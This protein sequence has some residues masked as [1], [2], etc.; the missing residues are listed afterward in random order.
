[1]AFVTGRENPAKGEPQLD[2]AALARF[3]GSLVF[4]MGVTTAEAWISQLIAHGLSPST[5]AAIVR[6]SSHPDQLTIRCRLD[7]VVNRL[8]R[9]RIM[10]PPVI[11]IVGAAVEEGRIPPWFEQR[12]LFGQS[13]LITRCRRADRRPRQAAAGTRRRGPYQPAIAIEP[14]HDVQRLDSTIERLREFDWLVFSSRNGVHY[15]F[16]R[17]LANGHDIRALAGC[18]LAAVGPGT[19]DE[20]AKYHLR[21]DLVPST[22]YRG[23][24]TRQVPRAACRGQELA[25]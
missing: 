1:M 3:P 2:F 25:C 18:R 7:E 4:Y 13:I 19:A 14:A 21:C 10:R 23:R 12:P 15:F 17:L 20:L 11:V 6:R 8:H 24:R 16:E 9:P 5:P 22:E